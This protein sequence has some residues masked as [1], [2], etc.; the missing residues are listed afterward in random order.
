M[1][2]ILTM[3]IMIKECLLILSVLLIPV[4]LCMGKLYFKLYFLMIILNKFDII[5]FMN[6][7]NF[8]YLTNIERK[9]SF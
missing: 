2:K 8:N 4:D 6:Y 3:M 9:F 7:I 1:L 5:N